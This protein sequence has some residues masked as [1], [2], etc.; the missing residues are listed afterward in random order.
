MVA[1]FRDDPRD[2]QLPFQAW[3]QRSEQRSSPPSF[4]YAEPAP[5]P[6]P[7][8]INPRIRPTLARGAIAVPPSPAQINL[9]QP[10]RGHLAQQRYTQQA[11]SPHANSLQSTPQSSL[12]IQ[13]SANRVALS[14]RAPKASPIP[15]QAQTSITSLPKSAPYAPWVQW[16]MV[17]QKGI[18]LLTLTLVGCAL[19]LYGQSVYQHRQ[20][21]QSYAQLEQL[22]KLE[23]QG[24]AASEIMKQSLAEEAERPA[25]HMS[26]QMPNAA[27]SIETV[28]ARAVDDT[29]IPPKSILDLDLD[30]PMGY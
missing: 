27:V 28:P 3:T 20:W 13:S 7:I 2:P 24:M 9:P 21:G 1:A 11:H 16:L 10:T 19:S 26:S 8:Q 22:Q 25:S 30:G 5:Q 12:A 14:T 4:E 6:P 23:Q 15:V 29:S 17:G 18:C